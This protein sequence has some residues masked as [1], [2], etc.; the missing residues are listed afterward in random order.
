MIELPN[1][2]QATGHTCGAAALLSICAYYGRGPSTEAEIVADMGFGEDGSD[3]AHVLRATLRYG[4]H[5]R[6]YRP[7][8]AH[9]LA[10]C[11]DRGRPVLMMLQAWPV[12]APV[13]GFASVWDSG[14]WVVAIG[15]DARGVYFEDPSL[16]DA[17]GFLSHEAL[18]ERWHDIEGPEERRVHRY[19][20]EIWRQR[21][22]RTQRVSRVRA[23]D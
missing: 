13:T 11:L 23:I 15:Y 8:T 19:G 12:T 2:V 3:P 22:V 20:I 1:T 16:E 18:D 4:L 9:Q 10:R 17:R 5:A 21:V 7:M 6:E 14:H